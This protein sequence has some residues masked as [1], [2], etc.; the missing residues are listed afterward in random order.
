MQSLCHY[1]QWPQ[2]PVPNTVG[3]KRDQGGKVTTRAGAAPFQSC[4]AAQCTSVNTAA[5]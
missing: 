2:I 5:A 1:V 3:L 4:K